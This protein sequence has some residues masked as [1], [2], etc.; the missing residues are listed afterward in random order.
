MKKEKRRNEI[1][2]ILN[3]LRYILIFIISNIFFLENISHNFSEAFICLLILWGLCIC[4]CFINLSKRIIY[5]LFLISFFCFFFGRMFSDLVLFGYVKFYFT[6]KI[7]KHM[8]LSQWIALVF[9]QI[10]VE[11]F[12]KKKNK[13]I[14]VKNKMYKKL[15]L[16]YSEKLFYIS[17]I[18]SFLLSLEKIIFKENNNYVDLYLTF[19]SNFPKIIQ[20]LGNGYSILVLIYFISFPN[21][22]K[23]KFSILIS[24]IIAIM[25]LLTGTRGI[26]ILDIIIIIIY[27]IWRQKITKER[28][29]GKKEIFLALIM[30]P[31]MIIFLSLFSYYREGLEIKNLILKEQFFRFFKVTG[32][33]V[34]L[35]GYGIIYKNNFPQQYYSFGEVIDYIKYNP[36]ISILLNKSTPLRNTIEYAMNMH[37]YSHTISYF[38]IPKLYVLGHGKGSNYIAELY[39]DFGYLGVGF[40]N[41]ILGYFM[42]ILTRIKVLNILRIALYF[43]M[44]KM[45]IFIPRGS[46]ITPLTYSLNLTY[47]G[48]CILLY[49]FIKYLISVYVK[50]R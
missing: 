20:V 16:K 40:F 39:H 48:I 42:V 14:V 8:L 7:V 12:E 9:L 31:V 46:F 4:Y 41:L 24:I 44:V 3:L 17:S 26:A 21:T 43:L 37:S 29:I 13:G 34:D 11:V 47:L 35:L 28:W 30:S 6:N 18:C 10:G 36:L 1:R 38:I 49:I 5:F 45:L 15:L 2:I 32:N 25:K 19:N 27:L 50:E 23:I 22:K 33:T